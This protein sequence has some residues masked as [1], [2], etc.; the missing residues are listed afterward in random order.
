MS[1]PV[2]PTE[3]AGARSRGGYRPGHQQRE[4]EA[5]HRPEGWVSTVAEGVA[6]SDGWRMPTRPSRGSP[7]ICVADRRR[8]HRRTPAPGQHM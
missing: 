2:A 8:G 1:N 6:P 5:R 7:G 4:S 3:S